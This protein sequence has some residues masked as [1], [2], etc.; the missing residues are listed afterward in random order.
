MHGGVDPG[1]LDLVEH[2][3]AEHVD[4]VDGDRD[5]LARAGRGVE[6]VERARARGAEAEVLPAGGVHEPLVLALGV[7][8]QRATPRATASSTS[9]PM[10]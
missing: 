2:A 10:V 1:P 9:A 4:Q 6:D 5:R 8:D 7:D 3:S